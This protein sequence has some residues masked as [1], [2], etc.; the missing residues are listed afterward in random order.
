VGVEVGS[1]VADAGL[2]PWEADHRVAV[3]GA[4]DPGRRFVGD[5]ERWCMVSVSRSDS[6]RRLFGFR[7][8]RW[9]SRVG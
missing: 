3:E 7:R 9:K 1:V 2:G 6:F 4:E 8:Q 5:D